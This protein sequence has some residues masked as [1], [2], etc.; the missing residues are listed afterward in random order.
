M[1]PQWELAR[2]Q[3]LHELVRSRVVSRC[4]W[5][6]E[7]E[8]EDQEVNEAFSRHVEDRIHPIASLAKRAL[9]MHCI[10]RIPYTFGAPFLSPRSIR[11]TTPT[12]MNQCHPPCS[13][14]RTP[15]C[16]Y[17]TIYSFKG[18]Q[19]GIFNTLCYVASRT[20]RRTH[21]YSFSTAS[22]LANNDVEVYISKVHP[23]DTIVL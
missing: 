19:N 16:R 12:R 8:N 4:Q 7:T 2:F 11:T 1:Q 18:N 23:V 20:L 17:T 3:E 9:R 13:S 6:E 14:E 22:L 21:A 10:E 15:G 5:Q